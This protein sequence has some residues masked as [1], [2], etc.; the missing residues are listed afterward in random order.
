MLLEKTGVNTIN[1]GFPTNELMAKYKKITGSKIK[2]IS[3]V[4]PDMET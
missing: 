4:A 1:I 3:Q 2:V